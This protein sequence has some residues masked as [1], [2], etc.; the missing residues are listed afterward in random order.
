MASLIDEE[1]GSTNDPRASVPERVRPQPSTTHMQPN[2]AL[3]ALLVER[4]PQCV[5]IKRGRLP[6]SIRD[7]VEKVDQISECITRASA[8]AEKFGRS[9]L[10]RVLRKAQVANQNQVHE[11]VNMLMKERSL[12]KKQQTQHAQILA[13]HQ[14]KWASESQVLRDALS[15]AERMILA[16]EARL[17]VQQ[18]QIP[19]V[20]DRHAAAARVADGECQACKDRV[21]R[22]RRRKSQR[23]R[24][25]RKEKKDKR[26]G[27]T[28]S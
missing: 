10:S 17:R 5:G 23:R 6:S 20:E 3:D 26:Q 28:A 7:V 21:S 25:S 16:K 9:S 27:K 1:T 19:I 18:I 12:R 15:R 2:Q 24:R 11:L 22:K 4:V 14:N 8:D 13:M